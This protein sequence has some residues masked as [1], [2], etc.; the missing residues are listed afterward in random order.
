M[1]KIFVLDTNVLIS[2]LLSLSSSSNLI[3][4]RTFREGVVVYSEETLAELFEKIHLPRFDKYVPLS[5]RTTFYHDFKMAA[6]PITVA[7][8]LQVC[9]DP[10]DEKFLELAKSANADFII[11]KDADLL[12]LHPFDGIPILNVPQFL[13]RF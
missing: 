9:R 11:S 5:R 7:Y 6:F 1:S 4:R 3:F 2:A 13:A 12:V 10:K 8:S